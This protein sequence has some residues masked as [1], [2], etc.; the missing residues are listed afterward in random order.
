MNID[1]IS[2]WLKP[3]EDMPLECDGMTRILSIL[4]RREKIE[5][6]VFIGALS[7]D[8]VGVIAPHFWIEL[9]DGWVCDYRARMWLGNHEAVPHG[10]FQVEEYQRYQGEKAEQLNNDNL[11]YN[12]DA[13]LFMILAGQS[14]NDYPMLSNYETQSFHYT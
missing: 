8:D 5:H 4:F 13:L 9:N 3:L 11:D 12:N 1:A 6:Q 14:L 7:I 2:E 10:L